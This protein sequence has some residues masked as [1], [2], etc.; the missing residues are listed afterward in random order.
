MAAVGGLGC[1]LG[2]WAPRGSQ[3]CWRCHPSRS[4]LRDLWGERQLWDQGLDEAVGRDTERRSQE[5]S[6]RGRAGAGSPRHDGPRLPSGLPGSALSLPS[7]L[8]WP[9]LRG[10]SLRSRKPPISAALGVLPPGS[11]GALRSPGR[12]L[13]LGSD[14]GHLDRSELL[15]LEVLPPPPR[16]GVHLALPG[17][18]PTSAGSPGTHLLQGQLL[19]P[20][21][22]PEWTG[23]RLPSGK[24]GPGQGSRRRPSVHPSPCAPWPGGPGAGPGAGQRSPGK[25]SSMRTKVGC[26]PG[27]HRVGGTE[28]RHTAL[29][30]PP[31]PALCQSL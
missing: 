1:P 31:S 22:V 11:P 19:P 2:G 12:P 28:A 5:A 29:L 26:P 20:V 3:R 16:W 7:P 25:P 9:P 30:P 4:C 17:P 6:E 27:P 13:C 21:P 8:A 14:P 24:A 18:A 15:I 23:P 10:P